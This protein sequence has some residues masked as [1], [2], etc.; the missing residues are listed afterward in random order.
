MAVV[1]LHN[2]N[3]PDK[4]EGT[5]MYQRLLIGSLFA[6]AK[7]VE[8]AQPKRRQ[9]IIYFGVVYVVWSSVNYLLPMRFPCRLKKTASRFRVLV[10]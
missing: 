7:A 5:D 10:V 6:S 4:T 2:Q 3:F 9:I 1:Y 8:V